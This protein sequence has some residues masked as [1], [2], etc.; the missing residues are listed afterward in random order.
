MQ[1]VHFKAKI[2]CD[3]ISVLREQ[4]GA[5]I[6]KLHQLERRGRPTQQDIVGYLTNKLQRRSTNRNRGWSHKIFRLAVIH[7]VF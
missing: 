3:G 4:K 5:E 1:S 6:I 2:W 7:N